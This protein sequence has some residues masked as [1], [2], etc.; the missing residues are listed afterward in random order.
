MASGFLLCCYVF[1]FFFVMFSFEFFNIPED[2]VHFDIILTKMQTKF[3]ILQKVA[4]SH[5]IR[6]KEDEI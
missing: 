1:G 3:M 4:G 2:C 5:E 6:S